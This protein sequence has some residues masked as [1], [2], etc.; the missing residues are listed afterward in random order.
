MEWLKKN[1]R[2]ITIII[3]ALLLLKSV[4]SC[5]RKMSLNTADKK[6]KI[7]VDSIKKEFNGVISVYENEIDSLEGE[8]VARDF[9]IKDLTAD[10][11]IA[12]VKVNAAE[13]R[14]NAIQKTAESIK[15]NTTIEVKGVERDTTSLEN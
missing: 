6:H 8:L 11:K 3:F 2:Y 4:Q 10:L 5:N 14:A 15:A 13:R 7:E 12:G 9:M 1:L